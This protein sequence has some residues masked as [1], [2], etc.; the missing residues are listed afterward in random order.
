MHK[1]A[2]VVRIIFAFIVAILNVSCDMSS[3]SQTV[4][5][6]D[7]LCK[8][9]EEIITDKGSSANWDTLLI[10]RIK[11]EIPDLFVLYQNAALVDRKD[12]YQFYFE[13][14]QKATNK[15]WDCQIMKS[16]FSGEFDKTLEH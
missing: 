16:Y 4:S 3:T 14:A 11:N 13:A 10:E 8:I 12:K 6:Y 9:Y 2:T 5:E 7:K 15:Q 1:P